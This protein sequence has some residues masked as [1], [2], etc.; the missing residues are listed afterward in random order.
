VGWNTK[1]LIDNASP[2]VIWFLWEIYDPTAIPYG[3][4][5]RDYSQSGKFGLKKDTL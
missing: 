5:M 4:K 3:K 2:V 1:C